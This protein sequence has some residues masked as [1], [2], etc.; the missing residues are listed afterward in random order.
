M[1]MRTGKA[2]TDQFTL[3]LLEEVAWEA[4]SRI[5]ERLAS[6]LGI[7]AGKLEQVLAKG[8]GCMTRPLEYTETK[9][10]AD[11]FTDLGLSVRITPDETLMTGA[12]RAKALVTPLESKRDQTMPLPKPRTQQPGP[13]RISLG[14][15]IITAT[16]IPVVL[17]GG[18]ALSLLL[19][20]VQQGF[21]RLLDGSA[22]Q[23]AYTIASGLNTDNLIAYSNDLNLIAQRRNV[24]FIK[25]SPENTSSY[26]F[27]TKDPAGGSEWMY[28]SK[29]S[30]TAGSSLNRLIDRGIDLSGATNAINTSQGGQRFEYQDDRLE[31]IQALIQTKPNLA[32]KFHEQLEALKKLNPKTVF[33]VQQADIFEAS[34]NRFVK[35]AGESTVVPG[36]MQKVATVQIGLLDDEARELGNRQAVTLLVLMS[37][38]LLIAIGVAVAVARTVSRPILALTAAAD[39]ISLGVLDAPVVATSS[40]ELGDLAEALE[41]MRQSLKL[42]IERLRRRK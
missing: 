19:P 28:I 21:N 5:A 42:S 41:R 20:S 25:V 24:G 7:D 29:P 2:T 9:R 31:T 39:R 17:I 1:T 37:V 14:L 15:K 3:N 38:T 8:P 4:H 33:S 11:A 22:A 23:I 12:L 18:A 27:Y 26:Y 34:G 32:P 10:L 13:R 6:R 35:I 36:N 30:N 40:D 16:L